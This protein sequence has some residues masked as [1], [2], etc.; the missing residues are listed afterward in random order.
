MDSVAV[1]GDANV[2]AGV[3]FGRP[4]T[5]H[6]ACVCGDVLHPPYPL[7]MAWDNAAKSS[8]NS[9]MGIMRGLFV[10]SGALKTRFESRSVTIL[11]ATR[12]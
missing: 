11:Q 6:L 7:S 8:W 4:S 2:D 9:G 1:Q 5:S 3:K 12:S 10:S